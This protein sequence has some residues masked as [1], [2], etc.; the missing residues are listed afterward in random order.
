MLDKI[1][2]LRLIGANFNQETTLDFFP[3][4]ENKYIKSVAIF[5][6]NGTG[7]STISRAFSKLS[8]H[9]EMTISKAEL[10]DKKNCSI[11]L[12]DEE[13]NNIFMFNEDF[14]DKNIKTKQIGLDTIIVLGKQ[15][16]IDNKIEEIKKEL[17]DLK[18]K[19]EK[20]R[21]IVNQYEDKNDEISPIY[22]KKKMDNALRGE[23]SWADRTSDIDSTHTKKRKSNAA[24]KQDT[25][26]KFINLVPKKSRDDLLKEYSNLIIEKEKIESGN[27]QIVAKLPNISK[28]EAYINYPDSI[29][30]QLLIRKI[31]KPILSDREKVLLDI[32]NERGPDSLENRKKVF[33]RHD[34]KN[35]PYCFQKMTS[36]YKH[37]LL[38]DIDIVLNKEVKE[39]QLALE[40]LVPEQLDMEVDENF[41]KLKSYSRCIALLKQLKT[42]IG[43]IATEISNKISNPYKPIK[44]IKCSIAEVAIQL[45]QAISELG[46]EQIQYNNNAKDTTGIIKELHIINDQIAHYDIEPLY[47]KFSN[48]TKSKAMAEKI[49]GEYLEEYNDL[50]EKL[51]TLESQKN[52]TKIASD[53]INKYL[54]YIFCS[55]K[56]MQIQVDGNNEYKLFSRNESVTPNK[57]SEGERN[58]LGLCYFFTQIFADRD[59]DSAY[60]TESLIVI[61][62]P[63]SS[64]DQENRVGIISFLK[65]QFSKLSNGNDRTR[66]II[67]SHDIQVILDL[68]KMFSEINNKRWTTK[69]YQLSDKNLSSFSIKSFNKYNF[70]L[71]SVYEFGFNNNTEF[72]IIIGNIMRQ[73]LEAFSTFKY[74]KGIDALTNDPEILNLLDPPFRTY[75]FN[76]MYKLVLNGESHLES[77]AKN[78]ENLNFFATKSLEEKQRIAKD[79]LGLIYLLDE[80][81]F[82][83]H[84]QHEHTI[85]VE[86]VEKHC[87]KIKKMAL[88]N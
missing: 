63:V 87:N 83:K 12:N 72:E 23:N 41:S 84:A 58:I 51:S 31:E 1:K 77:D 49:L 16:E 10:Y 7:K 2:G 60:K 78:L 44:N 21:N 19:G 13:K 79:I 68:D 73:M 11:Q 85:K 61:D 81:H 82:K 45:Q 33:E 76:L 17:E 36:E 74:Q 65:F 35:C 47:E 24:V 52:N 64:F 62:D 86:R 30:E 37:S 15:V 27:S 26:K 57:V 43:F 20:Q 54:N 70:Y 53:M 9:E 59:I 88:P 4:Q 25:Y 46:D 55:D 6:R 34:I 80:L 38:Q 5:G 32:L 22:C 28:L 39:H 14:V 40:K 69:F 67:L 71:K 18:N 66:I 75:Y 3:S 8:G 56:R 42:A 29:V 48:A 50:N